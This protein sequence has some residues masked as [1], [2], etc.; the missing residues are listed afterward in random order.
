[1]K[2]T[3]RNRAF[4]SL[5]ARRS[6]GTGLIALCMC[7]GFVGL[8][9]AKGDVKPPNE[10]EVKATDENKFAEHFKTVFERNKSIEARVTAMNY[11][12]EQV[13]N[14]NKETV[15]QTALK[16]IQRIVNHENLPLFIP[17]IVREVDA[18][19][20]D[21]LKIRRDY[22]DQ[23]RT[24]YLK[25]AK[26]A[27]AD[28]VNYREFLSGDTTGIAAHSILITD[29]KDALTL[30]QSFDAAAKSP[31]NKDVK[32]DIEKLK[33]ALKEQAA[34]LIFDLPDWT[35]KNIDA[36]RPLLDVETAGAVV[37]KIKD[38][39]SKLKEPITVEGKVDVDEFEK[40]KKQYTDLQNRFE[41]LN[42]TAQIKENIGSSKS[43]PEKNKETQKILGGKENITGKPSEDY[44]KNTTTL[45]EFGELVKDKELGKTLKNAP[46]NSGINQASTIGEAIFD[47]SDKA[48]EESGYPKEKIMETQ[49]LIEKIWKGLIEIWHGFSA[50][51]D[52]LKNAWDDMMT[53]KLTKASKKLEQATTPQ[54]KEKAENRIDFI[55]T[56]KNNLGEID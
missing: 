25:L 33:T 34:Q 11:F 23:V 40:T 15:H 39:I 51:I 1:M 30:R 13:K 54:D 24:E 45:R 12:Y 8:Q 20:F 50:K 26:A 38:E 37:E 46:G 7:A 17:L 41:A 52:A 27:A 32:T 10:W 9:A 43:W 53:E 16:A 2:N 28:P 42:K 14:V 31:K 56:N 18:K 4:F 47:I 44:K 6:I 55:T 21:N 22:K 29:P 36:L 48:L 5:F 3:A 19:K 49:N 35:A